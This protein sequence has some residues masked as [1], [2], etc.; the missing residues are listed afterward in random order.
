MRM[1]A[2]A[3]SASHASA[4]VMECVNGSKIAYTN[5]TECPAGY[6]AKKLLLKENA[7]APSSPSYAPNNAPAYASTYSNS[8]PAPR[9]IVQQAQAQRPQL[10][11]EQLKQ[12]RDH[13]EKQMEPFS[14]STDR[15]LFGKLRDIQH[16]MTRQ[17]CRI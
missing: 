8:N 17:E 7:P 16:Q 15:D 4:Q 11:C 5:E 3:V 9:I 13:I 6:H 10:T 1:I 12:Q 14:G 2:L